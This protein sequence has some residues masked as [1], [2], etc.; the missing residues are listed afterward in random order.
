MGIKKI[1]LGELAKKV[2]GEVLGDEELVI[3]GLSSVENAAAG[4]ITFVARVKGDECQVETCAAAVLVPQNVKRCALPAIKVKDPYLA[5]AIVHNY[6]LEQPFVA[7]GIHKRAWIGEDCQI[8]PDVT[9]LANVTLGDRVQIAARCFI[10]PGA[11]IGDDVVIGS[12]CII[13]PNVTIENNC[14]LGNRVI[15]HAGTVV[16]SDG[17][18]YAV[19]GRGR[20]IKRPQVGTVEIGNDVEIGANCCIDRAAFG[21]T[22]I[23]SGSKI[24][25]LVQIAHNVEVGENCIL[26][27]QVGIA[28]STRLGSNVVVGGQAAIGGHITL[29]DGAIVAGRSG[30][31]S[32]LEKGAVVGGFPAL[33]IAQWR[34]AATIYGKLPELRK[35]VRGLK[36]DIKQFKTGE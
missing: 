35:E 4:E 15:L 9:I 2:E 14:S 5:S 17:F 7:Q 25:N 20:H 11:Y 12:D 31:N 30:V 21:V 1:T 34:K 32:D 29:Q 8:D 26:V 6:F 13:H 3:S 24:D 22:E 16:G 28:G 19:D 23:K 27:A 18:G 33:P 10:Y 36:K